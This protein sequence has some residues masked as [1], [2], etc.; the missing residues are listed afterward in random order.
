MVAVKS[1][2][3]KKKKKTLH[4]R[5][6]K[7]ILSYL[8][9]PTD[10]KLKTLKLLPLAKQIKY[11]TAVTIFKVRSGETPEYVRSL[12]TSSTSRYGSNNFNLPQPH[13]DLYEIS[14]AFSGSSI[15]NSLPPSLKNLRTIRCLKGDLHTH[16]SSI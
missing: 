15:W 13:I 7:L 12:F 8:S 2:Y 5:T 6:A 11:N 10:D 1:I 3:K 4:R 14:L 16:L 9:I